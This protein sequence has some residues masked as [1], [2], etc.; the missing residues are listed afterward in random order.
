MANER[1]GQV[2]SDEPTTTR[3][4]WSNKNM[5]KN[6]REEFT[7]G[8]LPRAPFYINCAPTLAGS[9]VIITWK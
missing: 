4:S 3:V 6:N 9:S 8:S 2:R 5:K 7:F 1:L